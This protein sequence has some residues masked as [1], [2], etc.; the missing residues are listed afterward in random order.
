[1][2]DSFDKTEGRL[3][4]RRVFI[5]FLFFQYFQGG[6]AACVVESYEYAMECLIVDNVKECED[7]SL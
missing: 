7:I 2:A 4:E 1:M 5:H 6:D 3:F